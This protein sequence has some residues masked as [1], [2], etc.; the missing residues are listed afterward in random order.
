MVDRAD[1]IRRWERLC[2]EHPDDPRY[3]LK[4]GDLLQAA[5]R[6]QEAIQRYE[7]V[8]SLYLRHGFD[9]RVVAI[10][11]TIVKLDPSRTALRLHLARGYLQL[12]LRGEAVRELRAAVAEYER[13]RDPMG[14]RL[15]RAELARLSAPD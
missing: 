9:L 14:A 13:R 2:A 10:W 6:L 12:D 7:H 15:A 5:G 1:D 3:L 11:S 4:L 8:A